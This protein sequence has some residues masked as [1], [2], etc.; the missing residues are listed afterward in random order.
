MIRT[1]AFHIDNGT[2]DKH[3]SMSQ[4]IR[5]IY[6]SRSTFTPVRSATGIEPNVGRILAKSRINNRRNGLVGVL[7]FGDG[8]FFQCLEGEKFAVD[9]LYARLQTDGR[10][11]DIRMLSREPISALSYAEWAMKFVPLE[12]EMTRLMSERGFKS[13]DP[14]LFDTAMVHKVMNLLSTSADQA[15]APEVETLIRQSM[16][17]PPAGK[18]AG[19]VWLIAAAVFGI[20]VVAGLFVLR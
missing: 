1:A 4:L 20:V 3:Y 5:I 8:C 18:S 11:K 10:H 16:E 15:T 6:I 2:Y 14:Y 19:V 13:F 9:S 12:K 17:P 7:Y